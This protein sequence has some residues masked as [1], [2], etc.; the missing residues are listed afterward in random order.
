MAHPG[1]MRP[2]MADLI[3]LGL[4][5][6]IGG[7]ALVVILPIALH[8]EQQPVGTATVQPAPAAAPVIPQPAARPP[9]TPAPAPVELP[10]S[11]AHGPVPQADAL[12]NIIYPDTP[13]SDSR[14]TH[15]PGTG[16]TG[17]G[18]FVA[19]DGSLVT[20]AHVVNGC[21]QTRIASQLVKPIAAKLIAADTG[22]DIALL[23]A[24]HVTPPATLPV[25][26]P[27]APDGRL[28]VLGYPA[29]GGPLVPTETWAVLQNG[30][31][32]SAPVEFADP[33]RVIWATAPAVNHGFSGGPMLDPRNGEVVGIVRGMVDS[34]RLHAA[35][36]TIPVS[37]MVT[38]PGSALL[39]ALLRQ[40]GTDADAQSESGDDALD[41]ARRATVRVVCLY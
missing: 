6:A 21:R 1:E 9:A 39:T 5:S 2:W 15:Q 18:F 31:L 26:R 22:H 14:G 3:G 24:D 16:V 30:K 34:A 8:P 38:G 27:A 33:R 32:A 20:A 11:I 10:R 23:R 29:S 4:G 28:F 40:E 19:S 13:P 12:P 41:T 7:V 36:A 17:T 35:Q 25:G 37:G